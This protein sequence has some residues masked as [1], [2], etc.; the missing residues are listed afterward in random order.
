MI[1]LHLGPKGL[2]KDNVMYNEADQVVFLLKSSRLES[3][4]FLSGPPPKSK[5]S[6][7]V[8]LPRYLSITGW[9]FKWASPENVS[10]LPPPPNL[11][12]LA[13]PAEFSE[14]LES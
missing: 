4:D 11:L 5:A 6:V 12:G 9:F 14:V 13:S 8:N 2:S 3:G 10:R 7:A 1:R